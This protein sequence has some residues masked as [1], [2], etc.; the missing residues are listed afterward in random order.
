[1]SEKQLTK[2]GLDKEELDFESKSLKHLSEPKVN[3]N[4]V[5]SI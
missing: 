1:M 5:E 3:I 2:N 4:L